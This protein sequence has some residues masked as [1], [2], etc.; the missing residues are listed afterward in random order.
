MIAR[1]AGP[2]RLGDT[3]N[4]IP[5]A[6][7]AD[8]GLILFAAALAPDGTAQKGTNLYA[9]SQTPLPTVRQITNYSGDATFT[10]VTSVAYTGSSVG[11]TAMPAGPGGPEEVH[12]IDAT[13]A[14][15][16]TLATD[17]EGCIQPLCANC[18]H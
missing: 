3:I 10:G 15:D 8:G 17:K 4:L 9:Y 12:V 7:N 14:A 6:T 1:P 5:P 18:F 16:R 13:G 2:I 11:Y